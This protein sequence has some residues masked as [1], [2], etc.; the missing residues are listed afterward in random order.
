MPKKL[1]KPALKEPIQTNQTNQPPRIALIIPCYNEEQT[2]AKVVFDFR[3]EL[4]QADIYVFNN[5]STDK[6]REEALGAGAKVVHSPIK[7]KGAVIRDSFR[8]IEADIY[9]MVDGDDT[10][11]A[12]DVHKMIARIEAGA[13][14]V[15]GDRISNGE[16]AKE[17]KRPLHNFGNLFIRTTISIL[18][19]Q[20]VR[21][22]LTGYRVMNRRFVKTCP[23]LINGFEVETEMT[24]HA[25]EKM[26]RFEEI[27]VAY[28][29]RPQGSHSKLNTFADGMN[30]LRSILWLCKDGKP[31]IF[32]GSIGIL[33]L[34][35]ALTCHIAFGTTMTGW[36]IALSGLMNVF[37]GFSL[38]TIVRL[39][40]EQYEVNLMRTPGF[41]KEIEE[42]SQTKNDEANTH[43]I[44]C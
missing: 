33:L 21:D 40:R 8:Q 37:L 3:K 19:G 7:G 1:T 16:Y 18:F 28:R 32:F 4:P 17:N 44:L 36:V 13:D 42:A 11:P 39:N 9:I 24:I 31:L 30:I 10:Y 20:K 38:D 5:N 34:L 35:L 27:P 2:I 23:I 14:I 22:V 29:D 15:C 43:K 25:I 41:Y 12:E 6:T 26:F